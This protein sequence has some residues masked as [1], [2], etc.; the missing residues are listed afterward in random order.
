[1]IKFV[2]NHCHIN[3]LSERSFLKNTEGFLFVDSSI[4]YESSC[5]SLEISSQNNFVYS[6]LGFHPLKGELFKEEIL[7]S[8]EDLI[9][10]YQKKIIGIGEIGLDYKA[11]IEVDMQIKIFSSFLELAKKYKLPVVIHNRGHDFLI[12]EILDRYFDSYEKIIF[13]CFS[14]DFSFLEKILEK[15]GMVSFSLNLL[16]K[17]KLVSLL[18]EVPLE[19]LLLETDS[20]Y[21]FLENKPSTPLDIEKIYIF[22]AQKRN[23][24]LKDLSLK[25][26]SNFEKVYNLNIQNENSNCF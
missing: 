19:N 8:Y 12:L 24:D 10:K 20:P 22:V 17:K 5:L 11:N 4:D 15:R 26:L 18:R 3:S 23:I 25:I 21:M 1:M 2:D 13:H 9:V 6:C 14:Q 7:N 16:R